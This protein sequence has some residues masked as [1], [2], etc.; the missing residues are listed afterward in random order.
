MKTRTSPISITAIFVIVVLLQLIGPATIVVEAQQETRGARLKIESQ[1]NGEIEL[2]EESHALLIGVINY[3]P[4]WKRLPGVE[5]DLIDIR[6]VL[7]RHGFKVKVLMD[8]TR[9]K[10]DQAIREFIRERGQ[11][12]HN[13]L[14]IY[15]AG[16]GHTLMTIDGRQLGYLVTSD[17]PLPSRDADSFR[18]KTVGS[19]VNVQDRTKDNGLFKEKAISMGEIELQAVQIESKH[20]L[21]VFDSCFSGALFYELR[22]MQEIPKVISSKVAKPVRQFITAGTDLQQVP[23]DSIFK[24]EFVQGLDGEADV[25]KDR[26]VTGSELGMFL[27]EKVATYS[28]GRQTPSYGKIRDPKLDQGDF[29]FILDQPKTKSLSRQNVYQQAAAATSFTALRATAQNEPYRLDANKS[30]ER[31]LKPTESHLYQIVLAQGQHLRLVVKQQGIDVKLVVTDPEGKKVADVDTTSGTQGTE[32]FTL[33][34]ESAGVYHLGVKPVEEKAAPGRYQISVAELR[35]ATPR[36]RALQQAETLS[37][38]INELYM[39]GRYDEALRIAEQVLAI[40]DRELGEND[41]KIAEVLGYLGVLYLERGDHKQAE[42][43]FRRA[44]LISEKAI[45]PE[46]SA[47]AVSLNHL[48]SVY[49]AEGDYTMAEHFYQRALSV[50]EKT[51]GPDSLYVSN[52]L[53]NLGLILEAKGDYSRA[54][55]YHHRALQ[56]RSEITGPESPIMAVSLNNL[57]SVYEAMGVYT[58]AERYYQ[59]AL[60]I[61]EKVF[62]REHPYVAQSLH[63]LAALYYSKGDYAKAEP[64]LQRALDINRKA[65]GPEHPSVAQ[66]L[67]N[68]GV[69]Y[70][71][72]G[73]Y[74]KAEPLLQSA[75]AIREKS[76]GADHPDLAITLNNLGILYYEK[77]DYDKA[78]Q[79]LQRALAIRIKGLGPQHP[80]VA[81]SLESLGIVLRARNQHEKAV[82]YFAR[83]LQIVRFSGDK[84]SEIQLL[85]NM[86]TA[87]VAMGDTQ[88][89][90]YYSDQATRLKSELEGG[91]P[92]QTSTS[93]HP[94]IASAMGPVLQAVEITDP[95][96]DGA[97]VGNIMTMKGTATLHSGNHLWL[98]IRRSNSTSEW[99]PLSEIEIIPGTRLWEV[100]VAIGNL[101]IT[102]DEVTVAV[103]AVDEQGHSKLREYALN[104]RGSN[105]WLSVKVPPLTSP[106]Q[107]RRLK[108]AFG[109]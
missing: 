36:E 72:L 70:R 78:E 41:P 84:R 90:S 66:S 15:F 16:H 29:V 48:A 73:N 102:G 57:A 107:I 62:S 52:I 87:Y 14:I 61:T 33:I 93:K 20:V 74:V 100:S 108:R 19:N 27:E 99:R 105:K 24:V 56:I 12:E 77:K 42:P 59:Q 101:G 46:S 17:A 4:G 75:L 68:L 69:L 71:A 32:T 65:L 7:E 43:F 40:R 31:E 55:V 2:Y 96:S 83:A 94:A 80:H 35:Q 103:V 106:P 23:D 79:L 38:Q 13:R 82:E 26:Y 47:V 91:S 92:A 50:G 109:K 95:P 37:V 81:Q 28:R 98:L 45:G 1:D 89:A 6:Q 18:E 60:V 76:V 64:L 8:P 9:D 11:R 63:N 58:L 25:N 3:A 88:Q 104:V 53:N 85:N 34:T 97:P 49:Q 51:A 67:D 5:K 86:G 30:V 10:Y 21:F 54:I 39:R 22:G 44:L